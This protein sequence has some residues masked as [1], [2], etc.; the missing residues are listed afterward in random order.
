MNSNQKR[1]SQLVLEV[2]AACLEAGGYIELYWDESRQ[3]GWLCQEISGRTAS[4]L[5]KEIERQGDQ[6]IDCA[7]ESL[8]ALK[9][10][11]YE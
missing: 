9:S 7:L 2:A 4:C 11:S 8:A 1:P 6:A 3:D 5:W 10:S